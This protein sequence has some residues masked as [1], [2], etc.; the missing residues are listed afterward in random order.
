MY[1]G[2]EVKMTQG[3]NRVPGEDV[4]KLRVQKI[5]TGNPQKRETEKKRGERM[6]GKEGGR[7]GGGETERE[8]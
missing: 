6:R 4:H 3:Q 5:I 7:D 8:F 1:V 2:L